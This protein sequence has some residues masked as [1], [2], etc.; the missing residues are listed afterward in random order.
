MWPLA[1]ERM[2]LETPR[3]QCRNFGVQH[4]L[5]FCTGYVES[6]HARYC[7]QDNKEKFTNIKGL[8]DNADAEGMQ[9]GTCKIS[10]TTGHPDVV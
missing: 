5:R 7:Y 1:G 2:T 6:N 4:S 9:P 3:F 10:A 8:I